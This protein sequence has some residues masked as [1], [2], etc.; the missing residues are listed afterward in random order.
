MSICFTQNE[1]TSFLCDAA[2]GKINT[3]SNVAQNLLSASPAVEDTDSI[4]NFHRITTMPFLKYIAAILVSSFAVSVLAAPVQFDLKTPDSRF[5]IKDATYAQEYNYS[6]LTHNG[7]ALSVSGWS[8]NSVTKCNSYSGNNC[9]NTS[10]QNYAPNT[11][12]QDF[13]GK[14]NGLGVEIAGTPEHAV[15]NTNSDFDMLLLSFSEAVTLNSIYI[16]WINS[17]NSRS[18]V[19]IL[20]GNTSSF[21]SP[22]N[23]SWQSL[24]GNGWQ[25]AGNYNNVG[26]GNEAVNTGNISSKYWLIGA[27][28]SLLGTPLANNDRDSDAFKL[29]KVAVSRV[30]KVPE[31]SALF[32][33]GLGLLGLAVVRRR[34]H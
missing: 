28:N 18:D 33:F 3:L 24:I 17:T 30:I 14:W 27:Y 6:G 4:I 15:D 19:S 5:G 23:K 7:I 21:A 22:L 11:A 10:T 8:Y 25:S 12:H 1:K 9:T 32:L 20:A 34:S 26:L 16:G 31:P 2:H 13:V 29:E